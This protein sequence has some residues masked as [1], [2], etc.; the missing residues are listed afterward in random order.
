MAKRN[1]VL[2][3]GNGNEGERARGIVEMEDTDCPYAFMEMV[4]PNLFIPGH[5]ARQHAY[6]N[7]IVD[8]EEDHIIYATL[9]E[10]HQGQTAFGAAYRTAHLEPLKEE[11]DGMFKWTLGQWLDRGT[12]MMYRNKLRKKIS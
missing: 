10:G 11:S 4:I 8:G 12:M 3:E 1:F 6:K 2:F 5:R 7:V 9:H